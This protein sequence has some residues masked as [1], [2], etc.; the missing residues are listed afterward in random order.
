MRKKLTFAP[1][2]RIDAVE[3]LAPRFFAE[4][5]DFN[6]HECL[7]TDESD[8]LDFADVTGPADE[9]IELMLQRLE[10]HYRIDGRIG[11]TRI[12]DLLEHLRACGVA[13]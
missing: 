6:F 2:S 8:L 10:A 5:L 9:Q 11:S 3:D 7:V 1:Q 4:V 13:S 12:V